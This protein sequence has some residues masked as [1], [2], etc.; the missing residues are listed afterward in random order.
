MYGPL[1]HRPTDTPSAFHTYTSML[2]ENPGFNLYETGRLTPPYQ[3]SSLY[4]NGTRHNASNAYASGYSSSRGRRTVPTSFRSELSR[5]TNSLYDLAKPQ[6]IKPLGVFPDLISGTSMKPVAN[7]DKIHPLTGLPV[8]EYVPRVGVS[9]SGGTSS[10]L[11]DWTPSPD[12]TS[13]KVQALLEP[14]LSLIHI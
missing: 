1:Y 14:T 3:A 4:R 11:P 6:P 8:V 13:R 5:F 2:D 12:T 9:N 10:L 7:L